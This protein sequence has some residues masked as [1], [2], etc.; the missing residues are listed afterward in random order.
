M[1]HLN[2]HYGVIFE[3][4]HELGSSTDLVGSISSRIRERGSGNEEDTVQST[5]STGTFVIRKLVRN[6]LIDLPD[7][8]AFLTWVF[9]DG[10]FVVHRQFLYIL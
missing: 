3:I 7:Q 5:E 4:K 6:L 10:F 9:Q 8:V 1:S 2:L